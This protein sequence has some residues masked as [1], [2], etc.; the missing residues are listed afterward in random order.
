M[1]CCDIKDTDSTNGDN[2]KIRGCTDVLFLCIF[3]LFLFVM[4]FIA[5]F[6]FVYG[7]PLRLIHGYDSF[8]NTCGSSTNDYIGTDLSGLDLSE[9]K[10]LYYLDVRNLKLSLQI[11]V[12]KCPDRNMET[13]NDI[14]EFYS[15]THSSLCS[16]DIDVLNLTASRYFNSKV[17]P[18]HQTSALHSS[19]GPCPPF[20]VYKSTPILNRCVPEAV[21]DITEEVLSGVYGLLNSWKLVQQILSDVYKAWPQI[22]G[23]TF[24][25]LILSLV[26]VSMLHILA[27]MIAY[28][29]LCA[30]CATSIVGTVFVWWTYYRVKVKLDNTPFSQLLEENV[31]NEH[32][33]CIYGIIC[34]VL[35][36]ILLLLV[37]A[38]RNR[39]N[40]LDT[41]FK[42]SSACLSALPSLF[43]QPVI[44]F[45]LLVLFFTLWISVIV[46]LATANYP[47]QKQVKP[48]SDL[49]FSPV[50]TSTGPSSPAVT[51]DVNSMNS[52]TRP[53]TTMAVTEYKKFT[54]V[55]YV[56]ATW[57]TY[58]W[59]VYVFGLI[60]IS[61][62]ILAC[63]QMVIA[64][65][66][67]RWYFNGGRNNKGEEA[68]KWLVL[69]SVKTLWMYHLGSMALG[70]LLITIFKIPRLILSFIHQ[71]LKKTEQTS[72]VSQCCLRYCICCFTGL[73][74]FIRYMN[75]NAYTVI[76]I[77]GISFCPGAKR[78]WTVLA[79]NALNLAT[80]NSVGDF[81]L[82]LGK[83][84]V[85]AV[86][87]SAA[88][89]V[90]REDPNLEF[91]SAPLLVICVFAF[92]IAHCVISL[93][94]IVIDTLF[95]CISEDQ[96]MNGDEG[97]WKSSALLTSVQHKANKRNNNETIVMSEVPELTPMNAV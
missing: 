63:Q 4:I 12:E 57:I 15:R 50:M 22:L 44:S 54:L 11:C 90:L 51:Y 86:T 38:T 70:A 31:H 41:L 69:K 71:R 92:F 95:L 53:N 78:A 93:Y 49:T 74:C 84:I 48:F 17:K 18:E 3:I 66:V 7:N 80:V 1:A 2:I 34:V 36:V 5:G 97:Q 28:I 46:C 75:H 39:L 96:Y 24:L 91:F 55:Q 68:S 65:A 14:Q 56:D 88:I 32:A 67:A 19:L 30:I 64:G 27:G 43:I 62:F 9:K 33:L 20:P 47:G 21:K 81:I 60:W 89:L 76:A 58:M 79:S 42:E 25:S 73:E 26:V 94:E 85:T 29:I 87:G 6:A 13:M 8:G 37:F 83:C 40:F 45:I 61:E 35:T 59:W 23:F 77:Q 72:V 16:Y 82:F 10:F 52:T